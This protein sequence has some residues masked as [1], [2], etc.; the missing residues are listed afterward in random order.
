[1]V[2]ISSVVLDEVLG[3]KVVTLFIGTPID[4]HNKI[5]NYACISHCLR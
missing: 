1:M 4:R 2:L 3:D 5:H